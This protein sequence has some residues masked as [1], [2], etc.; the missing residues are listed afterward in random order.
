VVHDAA[1]QRDNGSY[2]QCLP[3]DAIRLSDAE[4]QDSITAEFG[5][6]DG[7]CPVEMSGTE[8]RRT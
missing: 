4:R 6:I 5:V 7:Q 3:R 2:A 8:S 1:W